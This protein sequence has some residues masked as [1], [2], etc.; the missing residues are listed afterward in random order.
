[1]STLKRKA[2]DAE[3]FRRVR[4]RREASEELA[5][6]DAEQSR[7]KVL[8]GSIDSDPEATRSDNEVCLE[9][10]WQRPIVNFLRSQTCLLQSLKKH[11]RSHSA[12]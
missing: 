9:K 1:M 6:E 4:A 2:L 8:E 5:S 7:E 3:V 11:L 10:I 12:H